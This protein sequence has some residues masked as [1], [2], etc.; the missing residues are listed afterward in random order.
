MFNVGDIVSNMSAYFR[1]E[2]VTANGNLVVRN[3]FYNTLLSGNYS[4]SMFTLVTP[5]EPKLTGMTQFF[6]D[7]ENSNV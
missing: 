1:V 7:K 4:P 6:K 5:A 2:E 3:N